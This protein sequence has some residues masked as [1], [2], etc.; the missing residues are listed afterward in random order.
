MA[1]REVRVSTKFQKQYRKLPKRIQAVAVERE[2][3]FKEDPFNPRLDT[4]KLHG[5]DKEAWSF[6]VT[7]SHRIKFIFLEEETV[8]FLEIGT[9]DIYR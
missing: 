6:S 1:V 3:I 8:L 7:K 2:K 4:H 5:K 9:H